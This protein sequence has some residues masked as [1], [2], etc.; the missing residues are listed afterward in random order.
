VSSL[1]SISFI[2]L[3]AVLG[4]ISPRWIA[5][6]SFSCNAGTPATDSLT[7]G[8]KFVLCVLTQNRKMSFEVAVNTYSSLLLQGSGAA[9]ASIIGQQNVFTW[10]SAGNSD[11]S[12]LNCEDS[13]CSGGNCYSSVSCPQTYMTSDYVVPYVNLKIVLDKGLLHNFRWVNGCF[14]DCDDSSCVKSPGRITLNGS[15]V[16]EESGEGAH[17]ASMCGKL[18]SS[19]PCKDP[20]ACPL[21]IFVTWEG[22]DRR[23]RGLSSGSYSY[24]WL[25]YNGLGAP[26][27]DVTALF[28]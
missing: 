15:T 19:D 12:P 5:A 24:G 18:R 3:F 2:W 14:K 23:G 8:D 21:V 26:I 1:R 11:A 16:S 4:G 25:R 9:S 28:T 27:K 17:E 10:A 13:S 20:E 6:Q 7:I 22:S